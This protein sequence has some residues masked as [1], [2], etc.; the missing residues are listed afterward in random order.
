MADATN[1]PISRR[2]QKRI[3]HLR[4]LTGATPP[5]PERALGMMIVGLTAVMFGISASV[6]IWAVALLR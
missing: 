2:W 6:L 4:A 1:Q 3:K 5:A